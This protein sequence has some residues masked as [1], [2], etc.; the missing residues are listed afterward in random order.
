MLA[1]VHKGIKDVALLLGEI[2]VFK[3]EQSNS[4]N[5]YTKDKGHVKKVSPIS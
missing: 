3:K 2:S 5:D 1:K 4:K